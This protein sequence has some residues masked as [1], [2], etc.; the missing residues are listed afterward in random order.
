MHSSLD[1]VKNCEKILFCTDFYSEL[2]L[3]QFKHFGTVA[4]AEYKLSILCGEPPRLHSFGRFN[5]LFRASL[6]INDCAPSF[7]IELTI[8]H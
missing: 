3:C 7:R 8:V 6:R 5:L 1:R 4:N 2:T